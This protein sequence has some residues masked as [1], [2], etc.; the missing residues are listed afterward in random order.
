S[1]T[2]YITTHTHLIRDLLVLTDEN[3]AEELN[4]V[5]NPFAPIF[6]PH[7]SFLLLPPINTLKLPLDHHL[8]T[9]LHFPNSLQQ[10]ALVTPLY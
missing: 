7:H 4:F 5:Q 3:L 1:A 9:P 2:K 10:Q 6:P 8:K